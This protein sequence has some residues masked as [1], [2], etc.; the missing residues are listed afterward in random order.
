MKG[1]T[2][3]GQ[4]P[5]WPG[6]SINVLGGA[7][8]TAQ[9]PPGVL[10]Q[11]VPAKGLLP[12]DYFQG[13]PV[14]VTD[15][16]LNGLGPCGETDVRVGFRVPEEYLDHPNLGGVVIQKMTVFW[17]VQDCVTLAV[18][19]HQPLTV[20]WE[21]FEVR[22]GRDQSDAVDEWWL[23]APPA[24][25]GTFGTAYWRGEAAFFPGRSA[26]Q[27]QLAEPGQPNSSPL[28]GNKP[29]SQTVPPCWGKGPLPES[30][31]AVRVLQRIWS[32]CMG[33]PR[34]DAHAYPILDVSRGWTLPDK[35]ALPP[36]LLAASDS[37]R[38]LES[39]VEYLSEP[40][41]PHAV[42]MQGVRR[43]SANE[44]PDSRYVGL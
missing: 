16:S 8:Q 2:Y 43:L 19:S 4:V 26:T 37:T 30:N 44:A 29:S 25:D 32:C 40:V 10:S 23:S 28:A 11:Q 38:M 20:F 14:V 42:Q 39:V 5:M 13:L 35:P 22:A 21:A 24:G 3:L 33:H 18:I 41:L 36:T 15:E 1:P 34:I 17:I 6:S 9:S 7:L 31:A 12:L 27:C